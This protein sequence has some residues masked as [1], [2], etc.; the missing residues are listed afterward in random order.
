M[1]A[2]LFRTGH[3]QLQGRILAGAVLAAELRKRVDGQ[4]HV[5]LA[6]KPIE[7]EDDRPWFTEARSSLAQSE[8]S[9][10]QRYGLSPSAVLYPPYLAV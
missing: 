1:Y 3:N 5:L 9:V 4:R 6:L 7:R 2:L 8:Q 10:R